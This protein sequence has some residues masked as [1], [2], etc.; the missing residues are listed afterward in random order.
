MALFPVN[1]RREI[2]YIPLA[3]QNL[4]CKKTVRTKLSILCHTVL[5]INTFPYISSMKTAQLS[6][7]PTYLQLIGHTLSLGVQHLQKLLYNQCTIHQCFSTAGPWPG[8]R[9]CHQL[10]RAV[11]G[12]PGVCHFN[13][14]SIFHE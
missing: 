11:R 2:C 8:T 3:E 13:F 10:Y 1:L 6:C 5:K 12:S 4:P 9:P 14:L 7:L